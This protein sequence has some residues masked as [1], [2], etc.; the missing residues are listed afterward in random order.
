MKG[1]KPAP[2]AVKKLRGNPGKRKLNAAEPA[3]ETGIPDPPAHLDDVAL[4]EWTRLTQELEAKQVITNVDMTILATYCQT[5]SEWVSLTNQAKNETRY[6]KTE[7]GYQ[8]KNLIFAD[9]A[10]LRKELQN[11]SAELGITPSSRTRVKAMKL[12]KPKE[13][14]TPA[15]LRRERVKTLFGAE[16]NLNK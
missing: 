4:M 11:Y 1:R 10:K 9:I 16:L 2:T 7:K 8:Y 15:E 14:T 13:P 12:A 5:Y 3:F 6:L